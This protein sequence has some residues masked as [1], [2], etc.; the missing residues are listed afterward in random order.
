M[1]TR[2]GMDNGDFQK[3]LMKHMGDQ[4]YLPKIQKARSDNE[5]G[6]FAQTGKLYKMI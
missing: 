4:S 2:I 6:N 5:E 1:L 3:T